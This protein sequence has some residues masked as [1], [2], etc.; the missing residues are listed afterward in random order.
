MDYGLSSRGREGILKISEFT[1]IGAF[2]VHKSIIS[3]L[4]GWEPHYWNFL[5]LD[6]RKR[7]KRETVNRFKSTLM[8][9][10]KSNIDECESDTINHLILR[11]ANNAI[12]G[13]W[14]ECIYEHKMRQYEIQEGIAG[15]CGAQRK[16]GQQCKAKAIYGSGRCRHHGGKSTGPK[17]IDGNIKSLSRLAQYRRN[18]RLLEEKR[19]QLIVEMQEE[20]GFHGETSN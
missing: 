6:T 12:S 15:P 18:P 3:G 2:S 10:S 13:F 9:F 16:N 17:T 4:T 8:G 11:A 20:T 1:Q 14:R 5:T 19:R 7:I